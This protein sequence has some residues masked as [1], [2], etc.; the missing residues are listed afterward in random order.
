MSQSPSVSASRR[1]FLRG[2][3]AAPK[4]PSAFRPPWTNELRL[5]EHCTSCGACVDACETSII[6][7]G[8]DKKPGLSFMQGECTFCQ[9]CVTA[10]AEPVFNL[11]QLAPWRLGVLIGDGCLLKAGITCQLCTDHCD[12]RALR[13]DLRVSPSGA[14]QID[15]D[16]CSGCGACVAPCPASAIDMINPQ[17]EAGS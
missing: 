16:A 10:C 3:V 6:S 4:A 5:S 8:P 14:I 7:I 9:A 12:A 2:R 15:Q 13:F 17:G 1:R 11:G